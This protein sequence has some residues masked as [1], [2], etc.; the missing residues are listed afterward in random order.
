MAASIFPPFA[1]ARLA[2]ALV[3]AT[4][5]AAC[6]PFPDWPASECSEGGCADTEGTTGDD[7]SGGVT[8]TVTGVTSTTTGATSSTAGDSATGSTSGEELTTTGEPAA[9]PMIDEAELDPGVIHVAGP[10]KVTIATMFADGVSMTLKDGSVVGLG[11]VGGGIF[12][13]EILATSGLQNGDFEA[14]FVAWRGESESTPRVVPY[15]IALHPPGS[16]A[17]WAVD[18]LNGN[19]RVAAV[20]ALSSGDTIEFGSF[21]IDN[22]D[23]CYVRRRAKDGSWSDDNLV[24]VLPGVGCTAKDLEIGDDGSLHLLALREGQG[25]LR[26]WLGELPAWGEAVKHRGSGAPGELAHALALSPW[27]GTLAVC[28]STTTTSNFDLSDAMVQI[29]RPGMPG[30]PKSYDYLKE[31]DKAHLFDEVARGCEFVAEDRLVIV[32][33]VFGKH[34]K[35]DPKRNRRFDVVYDLETD[36]GELR[37][38]EAGLVTQSVA[39]DL[40]V[41]DQSRVWVL[42]YQCN[43]DCEPEGMLWMID[44]DG[45][46]GPAISL[47]LHA[48]EAHA[49]TR[50]RWSPAKY[51]VVASGELAGHPPAVSL[52]AYAP[53]GAQPLWSYS[54]PSP[55]FLHL[56]QGL[57]IGPY[58]EV[59]GGG[60]TDGFPLFFIVYG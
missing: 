38:A 17:L 30:Y 36:H 33:E 28:G 48:L 57:G 18:D 12:E 35:D 15:S 41:D 16:E 8:G 25:G 60:A 50:I 52:R 6:G 31:V 56:V 34:I 29:F 27:D 19:G 10:I 46:P 26:W 47:G 24:P 21:Y 45:D 1:P 22:K 14:S 9:P 23:A 39:R 2:L 55:G 13:G 20:G 7:P 40:A 44:S 53:L 49:P 4:I 37:V 11:P 3:S 58:G 5:P 32:G 51:L 54:H 42:G 59:Y 43:D